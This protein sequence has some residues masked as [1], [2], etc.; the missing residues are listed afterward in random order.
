MISN[1]VLN[2]ILFQFIIVGVDLMHCTWNKRLRQVEDDTKPYACQALLHEA[3]QYPRFPIEFK[4]I[5]LFKLWSFT[6]FFSFQSPFILFLIFTVLVFLFF[7][8]K[9]SL[10]FHYRMEV[11]DNRVQFQFLKIYTT[12]FSLYGFLI[13]VLTQH[14]EI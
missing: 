14:L 11:I 3:I 4:L 12:F 8:D 5:I 2:F 6:M 7:K 1:Q 9:H 10:Y 13:F